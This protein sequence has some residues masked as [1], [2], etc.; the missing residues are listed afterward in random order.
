MKWMTGCIGWLYITWC[1]CR[2]HLLAFC[3]W[4]FYGDQDTEAFA[5]SMS[6]HLSLSLL[7]FFPLFWII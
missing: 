2:R 4:L 1:V 7:L 5:F 3:L 6:L